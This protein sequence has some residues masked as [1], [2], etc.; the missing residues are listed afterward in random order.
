[1]SVLFVA[2]EIYPYAKTGG[3]ADVAHSLPEALRKKTTVYTVMPLYQT[4]DRVKFGIVYT[5]VTYDYWLNGVRH[6]F[7][8]F[9]REE[10][11][12]ELFIYN[13]VL[14]DR[15]GLYHDAYGDFGDNELRFGL[16]SY[17]VLELIFKMHLRIDVIHLNDWQA[18]LIAPLA[19][20]V[21]H[22]SQKIVLT[23]HNLAYQG[24]F[25]KS[26]M[27]VLQLDWHKFFKP[28]GLEYFDAV[29]FLK[30]GIYY[31]D[32]VTTVSP[33]YAQE[34]QTPL[35]GNDL[36]HTLIVN[37]YKLKGILNG[38]S[39]DVFDPQTDSMLYKN[40]SA[41]TLKNRAYNKKHLLK[42][43]QLEGEDKPLFAFIGRFTHQKG[44]DL[45]L[46]SLHY[47]KDLEVNIVILGSGEERYNSLFRELSYAFQNIHIRIGYDEELS[48]KIYGGSDFLIMPSLF[49][50]CGLN[51]LISMQYGAIPIVAD[52][53]GLRDT[54]SDVTYISDL[55]NHGGIGIKYYE[56]N[57]FWFN[58]AITKAIALYTNKKKL[59]SIVTH[60]MKIDYSWKKPAQEY[61]DI[62]KS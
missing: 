12:Y 43:L 47:L 11:K 38:I 20:S 36:E 13:P 61:L 25:P 41:K 23:I 3:L 32:F 26:A 14:C 19:K 24:I 29:N 35:F 21:Y 15:E 50:S 34:I 1:M 40:F 9:A 27:D 37:S 44:V 42:D 8:V 62:Y 45:I 39:Y 28:E 48:R 60:N 6:Q 56:H 57:I 54:V 5:G 16:F 49:E 55:K 33:S 2:S 31:S 53:G 58:F 7:D 17:S 46:E 52:T 10:N 18:S 59:E 30:A 4:I 51:Q 22:L